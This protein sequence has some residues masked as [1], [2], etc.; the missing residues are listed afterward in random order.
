MNCDTVADRNHRIAKEIRA[1]RAYSG[2]GR[3]E[4][5]DALGVHQQTISRWERGAWKG[6]PPAASHLRAIA[7][8]AEIPAEWRAV[9]F[10]QPEPVTPLEALEILQA[11]LQARQ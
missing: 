1:A 2:K 4:I 3:D 10:L 11:S 8:L 9:G 6:R 5:A 7:D